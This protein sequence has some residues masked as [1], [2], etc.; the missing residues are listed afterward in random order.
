M[1]TIGSRMEFIKVYLFYY[2][3]ELVQFPVVIGLMD[4]Q[5]AFKLMDLN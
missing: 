5:Y 2:H 3:Y 1:Y 4:I